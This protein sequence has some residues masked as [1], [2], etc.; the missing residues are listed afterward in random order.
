MMA[1]YQSWPG[2]AR[3]DMGREYASPTKWE[4][5]PR[6]GGEGA[7]V[8]RI[9]SPAAHSAATSPTSWARCTHTRTYGADGGSAAI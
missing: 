9:P 4:R 7:A 2:P 8:R 5:Q 1:A 3:E 6:S